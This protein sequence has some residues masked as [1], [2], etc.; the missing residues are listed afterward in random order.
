MVAQVSKNIW[1][2]AMQHIVHNVDFFG[3]GVLVKDDYIIITLFA[4]IL[5]G[6]YLQ[7]G[8]KLNFN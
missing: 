3:N 7:K 4:L 8:I 5:L 2:Q 1:I 6:P